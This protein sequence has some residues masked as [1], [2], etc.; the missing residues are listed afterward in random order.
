MQFSY[1]FLKHLVFYRLITA[2][3]YTA[4]LDSSKVR[5]ASI[6]EDV[7][8]EKSEEKTPNKHQIINIG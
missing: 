4:V 8:S 2:G 1:I 6:M 7:L 5:T 3:T